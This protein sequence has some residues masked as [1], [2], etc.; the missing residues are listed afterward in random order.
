MASRPD[1]SD[2]E[3]TLDRLP[4][5]AEV[6][7]VLPLEGVSSSPTEA[8][9]P[10]RHD[11]HELIWVRSGSGHHLIDG[12]RVP[13]RPGTIT[14][15]GRGQVHV[16]ECAE[17]VGGAVVRF[18]E[19]QLFGGTEQRVVPGWLLA[20]RCGR[21]VSVPAEETDR[22]EAVIEA[23]RGEV[24]RPHDPQSVEL[25]RQLVSVILLWIERWYD[26]ARAEERE[27]QE[28][29]EADVQLLRRF[30]SRL[31]SDFADHHDAA[32][33]ADALAVPP[34]A[35][36]RALARATGSSTKELVTDRVMVEAARLLRF[37]DLTAGQT[38]HR[39]GFSDPL[40][41]SR[42]FKRHYGESPTAYRA[43]V[44]GTAKLS[45]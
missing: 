42:A 6:V 4:D 16:F 14:L 9:E 45:A 22:L 12:S 37:S 13:A 17:D 34:A 21:T 19:E 2:G 39:V 7:D 11:Y 1:R 5:P 27:A 31:E 15:I 36:S 38:A 40:Y 41:F 23:L 8:R 44:R 28:A 20:G 3:L 10:H 25:Q 26:A 24:G 35:L 32:H 33:Y 30:V 18:G 43:R 29:D